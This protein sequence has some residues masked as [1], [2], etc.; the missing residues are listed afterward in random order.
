MDDRKG[1]WRSG[2]SKR[3]HIEGDVKIRWPLFWHQEVVIP[4]CMQN[5]SFDHSG[6]FFSMK[7]FIPVKI[8]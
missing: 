4:L 7:A 1:G 8:S 2:R 6:F 3:E 5:Y